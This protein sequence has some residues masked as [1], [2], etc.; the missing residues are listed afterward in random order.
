MQFNLTTATNL[1]KVNYYKKSENMYNSANVLA[2]RIKKRYDFTGRQRFI[3]TP[4]SYAGGVGSGSLPISGVANYGDAVITSKKV[5]ATCEIDRESIKA[6]ADDAGAFVRA[7]KETVQKCVESYSRNVSRILFSDG[8]GIL[9][10][11]DGATAVSGAGTTADPYIVTMNATGWKEANFEER[12]IVQVITAMNAY[13]DNSVGTE[14]AITES[15]PLYISEVVPS[16]KQIKLVGTSAALAAHVG[17]GT[18]LSATEGLCMQKSFGNDPEG[19]KSILEATSGSLFNVAVQ[20]RWQA[21]QV[22][23]GGAG[24]STDL[25][26]RMMLDVEKKFGKAPNMVVTS[27]EQY[28]KIL[29]LL[30]DHKRYSLPARSSELK[31]KVSFEGVEYM[32]TAGAV[33]IFYDRFADS[34]KVYF[35]NDNFIEVHHRPDHGWF[36][37]DGTVFLRKKGD[38]AYEA[39]YGGYFQNFITPSAHG[40]LT[41]LSV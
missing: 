31:G 13:P 39:R 21:T 19:F 36:T 28:R 34:D 1:F 40:I 30:E 4:L 17:G 2:G 7:T 25:M 15:N 38:D 26:N 10:R 6:S 32:S 37:D 41:G 18:S 33:G 35:L 9:G 3:T 27:Y 14:E 12:D 24:V 11:G 23:A 8:S 22:S 16:L 29:N 20:R 5:Y